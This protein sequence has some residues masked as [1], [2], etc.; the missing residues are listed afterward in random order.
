LGARVHISV[1]RGSKLSIGDK[2]EI[3]RDC[4]LISGGELS[5]GDCGFIGTGSVIVSAQRLL[6]GRDTLLA[7]YVT[8]RD[9]D[10]VLD[11]CAVPIN[12]QGLVSSPIEIGDNV[13][14]GTKASVLRGVTIGEG[15]VVAANAVVTGPVDAWT[16]VGG[17]PAKLIKRRDGPDTVAGA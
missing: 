5:I 6:I 15:A 1:L 9:Q 7:A 10:H 12:R 4:Q 16:I 8:I 3:E 14:I 17:I 2:V 13:W 11:D